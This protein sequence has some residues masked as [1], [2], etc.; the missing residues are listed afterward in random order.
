MRPQ[1]SSSL[2]S[3]TVS[4]PRAR[5]GRRPC[6][7]PCPSGMG[8]SAAPATRPKRDRLG[9]AARPRAGRRVPRRRRARSCSRCIGMPAAPTFRRSAPETL[10]L[11]AASCGP[12]SSTSYQWP[13]SRSSRS[14]PAR[15]PRPRPRG[16]DRSSSSTVQRARRVVTPHPWA[17]PSRRNPR[18]PWNVVDEMGDDR[19]R[20]DLPAR[21]GNSSASTSACSSWRPGFHACLLVVSRVRLRCCDRYPR[22]SMWRHHERP[23]ADFSYLLQCRTACPGDLEAGDVR[24]PRHLDAVHLVDNEREQH[25][26]PPGR[27]EVPRA[28]LVA[29]PR[30]PGPAH[31]SR[32]RTSSRGATS[33][34]GSERPCTSRRGPV[35]DRLHQPS[36]RSAPARAPTAWCCTPL[37]RSPRTAPR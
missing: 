18:T 23:H 25:R 28:P 33:R 5:P 17:P 32:R 12:S 20:A 36:A 31:T 26:A 19:L 34:V 6:P 29:A 10:E 8:V 7:R 11:L 22:T 14:R 3:P 15:G 2:T 1:I 4:P 35:V 9:A 16:G 24:V 21:T 30:T 13:R 27:V 37:S